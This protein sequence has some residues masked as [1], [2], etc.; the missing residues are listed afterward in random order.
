MG[1]RVDFK[2]RIIQMGLR[3]IGHD[4][5][6]YLDS[7]G[8]VVYKHLQS[9][10]TLGVPLDGICHD[11]FDVPIYGVFTKPPVENIPY[12]YVGYVSNLYQFEGNEVMNDSIRSS[13]LQ[14]GPMIFREYLYLNALRT[15]MS[16]DI[17]IRNPSNIPRVGDVFPHVTVKNTYDG[18]G[19]REYSFGFSIFAGTDRNFGFT[20]QNKLGKVR[21]VHNANALTTASS[22]IENYT[23]IFSQNI[24]EIITANINTEINEEHLLNVFSMLEDIGKK[25][26]SDV[27]SYLEEAIKETNGR[28]NGWTLFS[29]I[30]HF[31]TIEKNINIRSLLNNIAEK[32]LVIPIQIQNVL[33]S[34]NRG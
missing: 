32:V 6:E 25:K 4:C 17:L 26:R 19:A 23:T 10:D 18:S 31:S 1:I 11:S 3:D 12:S 20:F 5:F 9:K 33:D 21:Q 7:T 2:E 29:A 34:I 27:S 16:N 28:I 15:R 8:G 22:S 13:I 30:C 14:V 24:T